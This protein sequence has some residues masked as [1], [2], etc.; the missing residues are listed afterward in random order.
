MKKGDLFQIWNQNCRGKDVLEGQAKLVK[1][2]STHE[3]PHYE[4]W[5]KWIV[6]FGPGDQAERWVR[7]SDLVKEDE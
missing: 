6:E 2:L 4:G 7:P 1:K 3:F 5:E